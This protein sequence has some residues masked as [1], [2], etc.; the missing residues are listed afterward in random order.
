MHGV[1]ISV[2]LALVLALAGGQNSVRIHTQGDPARGGQLP[3]REG[4]GVAGRASYYAPYFEGGPLGCGLRAVGRPAAGVREDDRVGGGAGPRDGGSSRSG[5]YEPWEPGVEF[6]AED[7][8]VVAVAWS[9][10]LG[11][12]WPCGQ[13][14]LVSGVAGAITVAVQDACPGCRRPG[15]EGP[16]G[17]DLSQ[18]GHELV[19]GGG[20]GVCDVWIEP[21][22]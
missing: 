3:V 20:A 13:L 9:V 18:R 16:A 14:L 6:T 22:P 5:R 4:T 12:S 19:C 10:D 2:A 1:L 8:G 11:S 15:G 21:V 17:I 7:P